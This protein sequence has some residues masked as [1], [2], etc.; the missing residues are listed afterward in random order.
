MAVHFFGVFLFG[1]GVGNLLDAPDA[2]QFG[3]PTTTLVELD[4]LMFILPA[5]L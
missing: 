3:V 5:S 4:A 2:P 1:F